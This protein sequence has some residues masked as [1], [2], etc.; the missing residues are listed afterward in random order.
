MRL[1]AIMNNVDGSKREFG[2]RRKLSF[3]FSFMI[4]HRGNHLNQNSVA[5]TE[6]FAEKI[7]GQSRTQTVHVHVPDAYID[8]DNNLK[9]NNLNSQ[10]EVVRFPLIVLLHGL[11]GTGGGQIRLMGMEKASEDLDFVFVAPQ[12]VNRGSSGRRAWCASPQCCCQ[13][14]AVGC[15]GGRSKSCP[16]DCDIKDSDSVFLRDMID[17]IKSEYRID[18]S[19]VYIIGISNGGYMAYRMAW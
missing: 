3:L 2:Y 19:R 18:E 8:S 15:C 6:I 12:A 7:T 16:Y 14:F 5:A 11:G 13:A 10:K 17:H 1:Y 9:R 4:L